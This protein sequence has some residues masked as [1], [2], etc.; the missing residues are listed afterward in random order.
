[1]IEVT[2]IEELLTM[3]ERGASGGCSPV[4]AS[5]MIVDAWY[6]LGLPLN[7]QVLEPFISIASQSI[8][9]PITSDISSWSEQS[10]QNII[11]EKNE[12]D[13]AFDASFRAAC[14]GL[15]LFLSNVTL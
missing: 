13:L 2:K 7:R 11:A 10:R 12:H 3:A 4:D 1:M 15:V 5:K 14:K 6:K 9:L 8:H